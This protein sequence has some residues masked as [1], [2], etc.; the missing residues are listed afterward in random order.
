MTEEMKG[1]AIAIARQAF[2]KCDDEL[3]MATYIKDEFIKKYGGCFSCIVGIQVRSFIYSKN[4]LFSF[5]LG[6]YQIVLF[7]NFS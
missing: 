5:K 3:D 4:Y 7:D 2:Q 6:A 1:H